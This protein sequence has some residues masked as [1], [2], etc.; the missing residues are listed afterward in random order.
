[1][2]EEGKKRHGSSQS[3]NQSVLEGA[4]MDVVHLL[5]H[6]RSFETR[7]ESL[8]KAKETEVREWASRDLAILIN[9]RVKDCWLDSHLIEPFVE[10]ILREVVK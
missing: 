7:L 10:R 2:S 5:A 4:I 8:P 9:E 6:H 1:M 3:S